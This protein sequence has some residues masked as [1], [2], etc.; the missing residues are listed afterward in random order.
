MQ[1]KRGTLLV[2]AQREETVGRLVVGIT[3]EVHGIHGPAQ[4]YDLIAGC[5]H[6]LHRK[7]DVGGC[8]RVAGM[9][10]GRS[11]SDV[12][13]VPGL[14]SVGAR[15]A[16]PSEERSIESRSFLGVPGTEFDE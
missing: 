4:F 14:G 8:T 7:K 16:P 10:A 9:D 3:T 1:A 6:V 5:L 15:F 2:T 11:T 13:L 12:E